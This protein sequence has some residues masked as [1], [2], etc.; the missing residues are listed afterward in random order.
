M[1]EVSNYQKLIERSSNILSCRFDEVSVFSFSDETLI[2]DNDYLETLPIWIK[3][4]I[5][6]SNKKDRVL[7]FFAVKRA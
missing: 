4:L 5:C 1:V 7:S 2:D 6:T 3:L